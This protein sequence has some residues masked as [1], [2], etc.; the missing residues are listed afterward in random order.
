MSR[1]RGSTRVEQ[2]GLGRAALG[3]VAEAGGHQRRVQARRGAHFE[4]AL[5]QPRAGAADGGERLA[6]ER[7]V[8]HPDRLPSPSSSATLTFQA[9]KP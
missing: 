4:P 3:R 7:V 8:D 6:A 5:A 1:T 2:L 9:G